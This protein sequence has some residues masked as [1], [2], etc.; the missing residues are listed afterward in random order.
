[1]KPESVLG[2]TLWLA[3]EV[4]RLHGVVASLQAVMEEARILEPRL[5]K[6]DAAQIQ[7][8]SWQE[9]YEHLEKLDPEIAAHL[10]NR[11][12]RAFDVEAD[13]NDQFPG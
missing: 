8:D 3:R 1:M 6:V 2:L 7:V 10:D 4:G 13:P 5:D 9:F 11:P 12:P